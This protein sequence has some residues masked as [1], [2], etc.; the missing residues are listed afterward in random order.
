MKYYFQ[1]LNNVKK[2]RGRKRTTL[3]IVIDNDLVEAAKCHLQMQIRQFKKTEDLN[4]LR[5]IANDRNA[6]KNST[7]LLEV[8]IA[9]LKIAN[10]LNELKIANCY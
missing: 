2:F 5:K 6:W 8:G 1:C 10:D 7:I 9:E 3:A 4:I